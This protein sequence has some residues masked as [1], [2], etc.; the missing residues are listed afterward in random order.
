MNAI[1]K[2]DKAEKTVIEINGIKMEVDL[3][4]AKRIEE[5]KIGSKVKILKPG[6]YSGDEKKV[7]AGIIIGFEDFKELPTIIVAYLEDD[8]S[9]S[10]KMLYINED[11]KGIDM[12]LA[13]N[14]FLPFEK[15]SV[16]AK[17]NHDIEVKELEVADLK[18]KK[19]YFLNRFGAYFPE[20]LETLEHN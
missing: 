2:S 7:Y 16:I 10:V 6:P 18:R 9:P 5:F 1:V 4:S 3:R 12:I 20:I 11:S 15:E 13:G 17:M 8:Y 14:E 19:Q